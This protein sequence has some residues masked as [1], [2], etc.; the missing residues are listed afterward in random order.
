M[1]RRGCC[2][3]AAAEESGQRPPR[4]RGL[5]A[6][7]LPLL[8]CDGLQRR[9]VGAVELYDL[10]DDRELRIAVAVHAP[11]VA[12]LPDVAA[13]DNTHRAVSFF[14]PCRTYP[15]WPIPFAFSS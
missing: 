2:S 14:C 15:F 10:L 9:R 6:L 5:H 12:L 13:P 3:R 11:E 4:L 8:Y 1:R 7:Q